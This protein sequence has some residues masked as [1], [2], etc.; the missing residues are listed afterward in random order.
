MSRISKRSPVSCRD[1]LMSRRLVMIFA[2]SIAATIV[3]LDS[4]P[5]SVRRPRIYGSDVRQPARPARALGAADGHEH[6]RPA[7]ARL[8]RRHHR[9][10][11]EEPEHLALVS[12]GSLGKTLASTCAAQRFGPRKIYG[13]ISATGRR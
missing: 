3:A 13:P 4:A 8:V 12:A 2:R 5:H 11:E 10:Q 6:G 7:Q 1:D 9:A